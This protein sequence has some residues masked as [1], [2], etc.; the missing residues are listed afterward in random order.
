MAAPPSDT[1]AVHET[2]AS[3]LP[4]VA[5]IP[6][7]APGTVARVT[8]LDGL[9]ARLLPSL[10][11]AVTS[12]LYW[13]PFVKPVT[14]AD[15]PVVVA[16]KLPGEDVTVYCVIADPPLNVGAVHETVACALPP[17]ADTPVGDPGTV[18]GTTAF[19][20]LDAEPVPTLLVAVTANV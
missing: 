5:D 19:D 16:V 20:P 11:V 9:D 3:S 8:A 12:N 13:V 7:G 10:L 14:V 1:G 2:S 6:V 17:I 4:P 18:A 15:T